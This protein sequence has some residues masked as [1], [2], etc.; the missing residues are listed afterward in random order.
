MSPTTPNVMELIKETQTQ[1]L[2]TLEQVQTVS[3]KAAEAAA[4]FVPSAEWPAGFPKPVEVVDA[5]F[6]FYGKVL[7]SQ[8]AY[9][10][11]L[12]ELAGAADNGAKKTAS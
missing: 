8:K 5:A 2:A 7:E 1:A 3:L 11:R 10:T 6:G 9:A 4:A 12:S